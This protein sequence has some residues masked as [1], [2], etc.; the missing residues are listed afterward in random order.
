MSA[1]DWQWLTGLCLTLSGWLATRVAA[2]TRGANLAMA[3]DGLIP[4][5]MF[6]VLAAVTARP[7]FA[8]VV[9]F[10]LMGGLAFADATKRAVLKEPVLF[11]DMSELIELFRH[12]GLYLPYAGPARIVAGAAA[13]VALPALLFWLETPAFPWT[14]R[15]AGLAALIGAA[16]V[17]LPASLLLRPFAFLLSAFRPTG[18]PVEDSARF[19]S[20]ASLFIYGVIAR[21]ERPQRRQRLVPALAPPGLDQ[22]KGR[23]VVLVQSESFFDV[24]RLGRGLFP[25]ALL[26]FDKA[27]RSGQAGR[28]ATPAFGANTVRTEF[29]A[30]TGIDSAALGFDRFNPYHAFVRRPVAS[31]AWAMKARGYRTV[32]LHPYDRRFYGRDRVMPHLGF[33]LFVGQEVFEKPANGG[34]V[35]DADLTRRIEAM[36]KKERENLFIFAITME[37][38]GPWKGGLGDLPDPAPGLPD[39]PEK[40]ELKTFAARLAGANAMIAA[41]K[42]ALRKGGVLAFYGDHLPSFPA[43]FEALSFQEESTDYLIWKLG[44]EPRIKDLAAHELPA[45]IIAA[46]DEASPAQP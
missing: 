35:T 1:V 33:D 17:I 15:G 29:E 6:G 9:V 5:L 41:L 11:C 45:A 37:N 46:L 34:Y 39:V 12:P 28:L 31:L 18:E 24:R 3:F 16:L 32:C 23:P 19:G 2:M 21:A 4:M 25:R 10:A 8:G 30:I 36:L 40:D 38:H 13:A 7:M 27:K 14:L 43:A 22:F 44:L 26:A 20:V 42:K